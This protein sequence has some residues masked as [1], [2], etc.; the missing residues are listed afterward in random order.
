MNV[1]PGPARSFRH[2]ACSGNCLVIN[3]MCVKYSVLRLDIGF[4]RNIKTSMRNYT[5]YG[6]LGWNKYTRSKISKKLV[7]EKLNI[8]P[9]NA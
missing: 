7:Q 4:G 5:N 2:I 1:G 8:Y 3:E 9:Q 6:I